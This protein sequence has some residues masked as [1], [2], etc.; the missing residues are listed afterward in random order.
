[1]D[2]SEIQDNINKSHI[3][4][5]NGEI[6]HATELADMPDEAKEGLV[7]TSDEIRDRLRLRNFFIF[8]WLKKIRGEEY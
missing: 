4:L 8:P 3:D 7:P 6:F 5:T 2:N 1:M